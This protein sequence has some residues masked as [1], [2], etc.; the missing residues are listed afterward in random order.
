MGAQQRQRGR[1]GCWGRDC[2]GGEEA[3]VAA[4][5][6]VFGGNRRSFRTFEGES[7]GEFNRGGSTSQGWAVAVGQSAW[8]GAS[9]CSE[10]L[11][12]ESVLPRWLMLT[13]DL[14]TSPSCCRS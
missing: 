8:P 13:L 5:G 11:F 14:Q 2:A 9:L 12:R 4:A 10:S 7:G 6:E 1:G 3:Q